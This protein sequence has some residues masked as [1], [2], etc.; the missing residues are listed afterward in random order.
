MGVRDDKIIEFA[1]VFLR[2]YADQLNRKHIEDTSVIHNFHDCLEL[3][4]PVSGMG[5]LSPATGV[6]NCLAVSCTEVV[7]AGGL[8]ATPVA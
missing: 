4:S 5:A 2:L 8:A 1:S 3:L 6:P 7:A